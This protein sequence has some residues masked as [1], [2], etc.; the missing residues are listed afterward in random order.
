[1]KKTLLFISLLL[2][3][4]HLTFAETVSK[5]ATV[6]SEKSTLAANTVR[7]STRP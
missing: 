6:A 1:M 5:T 4:S 2:G 7:V 3:A